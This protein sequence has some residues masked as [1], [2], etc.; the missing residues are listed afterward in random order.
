MDKT[1]L[2][3]YRDVA[4]AVHGLKM[5]TKN[6]YEKYKD[7]LGQDYGLYQIIALFELAYRDLNHDICI[8]HDLQE[9]IHTDPNA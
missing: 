2:E 1:K 8:I 9:G 6:L 4:T 7:K 5:N 3:T